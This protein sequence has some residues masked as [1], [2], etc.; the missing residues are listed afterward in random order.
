MTPRRARRALLAAAVLAGALLPPA[1]AGAARPHADQVVRLL[2][3][4]QRHDERMPWARTPPRQREAMAVVVEGP[5]LLTTAQMVVDAT[6]IQAEKGGG[7]ARAPVRVH[8]LDHEINLALLAVDDAAFFA[9]LRPVEPTGEMPLGGTVTLARW[10]RGQLELA[11]SRVAKVRVESGP[12]SG[13]KHL[14]FQVRSDLAAGGWGEPLFCG[15]RLCGLTVAQSG[16][17]AQVLPAGIA[18]TYLAAARQAAAYPGFG[19]FEIEWQENRDPATARWL[20]MAGEPRGV[21]VLSVPLG[22]TGSGVLQ[23]RDVLLA[24][25]GRAIGADG[26]YEHPRYGRI[27]FANLAVEGRRAGEA[28]SARVLRG[29][30]EREVALTLR[31]YPA[32]ARLVPSF[33]PDR[34]S[35]YVVAAGLVFREL[36]RNYLAAFGKNWRFEADGR[37][38][39]HLA[40]DEN[41]QRPDRRRIVILS[42]VL[43]SALTDGY[44][45]VRDLVVRE[46]NGRPAGSVADV[47]E[48]F[49]EA[50]GGFHTVRFAPNPSRDRIVLDAAG[51]LEADE[52]VRKK[53]RIQEPYRLERDPLPDLAVSPGD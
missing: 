42:A 28:V 31:S 20:G 14:F 5:Y 16:D 4:F 41:A 34:P 39:T 50:Q 12:T 32:E 26:L 43:P 52:A 49:R 15:E 36:D 29:G 35:P 47:V 38:L 19:S 2:I 18:A 40:L 17:F 11:E 21:I 1:A 10:E 3:A 23:A 30:A 9:G 24:V 51:F 6:L 13:L 37:L 25:D 48:A 46:V 53:Y 33:R 44:Q 22:A 27:G 45:G 7:P 8:H